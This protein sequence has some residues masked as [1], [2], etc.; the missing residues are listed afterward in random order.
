MLVKRPLWVLLLLAFLQPGSLGCASRD[1]PDR[2]VLIVIDTLRRDYVA[3]YGA[4]RPTPN[5]D[6]LAARGQRFTQAY[7]AFHQTT[8]S[9]AALFTGRT[10]S[11]ES[12][13]SATP[14]DWNGRTWCGMRRYA[15]RD[16]EQPCIP[17]TIGTLAESLSA[18]GYPTLAVASSHFLFRPAGF[19]RGF[20]DWT[21][22]GRAPET[23]E[24]WRHS[25]ARSRAR[26]GDLVNEAVA[27]TLDRRETDR[28]FLYVH[29]MDAHDY[30]L[31]GMDYRSGV[32]EADRSVG[33]L[34][35]ALEQRGLLEGTQIL[36]TS[37]HGE[38]LGEQHPIEG[39]KTHAGNPSFEY[40]LRVP[41]IAAP[42]TTRDS[43]ALLRGQDVFGLIGELAGVDD[44]ADAGLD[45]GEMF[46]SE[47]RW[48]TYRRG[49]WKSFHSRDARQHLLFDL[50]ADPAETR[51][52]AA[53]HPK[54]LQTHRE[55]IAAL[56]DSL[57]ARTASPSQLTDEDRSQLRALGYLEE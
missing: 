52:L 45:A 56:A 7:S 9:M 6:A 49:R 55:R 26:T 3:S 23:H 38:R 28:F 39:R 43:D 16:T 54:V 22:V 46:L 57:A 31:R 53:K 19:S 10:P 11:L 41:L 34:I 5:I 50:A 42:A 33:E 17:E 40:L 37:D 18:A 27:A 35:R 44:G 15:Q 20:D 25:R 12:G 2:I 30:A 51:D 13:T 47:E 29:F 4:R 1:T 14:L 21:E 48:Q 24:G 8:M 36:L 32:Q